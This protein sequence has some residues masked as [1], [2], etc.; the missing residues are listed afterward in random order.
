MAG[1]APLSARNLLGGLPFAPFAK[2]WLCFLLHPRLCTP[3]NSFLSPVVR[4]GNR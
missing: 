4:A 3:I 2:G 1:G